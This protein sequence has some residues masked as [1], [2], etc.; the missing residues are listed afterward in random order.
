MLSL[1]TDHLE[2]LLSHFRMSFAEAEVPD[3]PHDSVYSSN[4]PYSGSMDRAQQAV[5][6]GMTDRGTLHQESFQQGSS[7]A[8]N[9]GSSASAMGQALPGGGL[10]ALKLVLNRPNQ[11]AGL[12]Q[13]SSMLNADSKNVQLCMSPM[14]E[15][16]TP[17]S[18]GFDRSLSA[19]ATPAQANA[20]VPTQSAERSSVYSCGGSASVN[21]DS[22]AATATSA[23][24]ANDC[25][26]TSG[27]GEDKPLG[28]T[29]ADDHEDDLSVSELP[30]LPDVPVV[31]GG[32]S[33]A[34]ARAGV[35]TSKYV[36]IGCAIACLCVFALWAKDASAVSLTSRMFPT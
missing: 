6:Q 12:C 32:E 28:S 18:T 19:P 13:L 33:G 3:T 17:G 36:H 10:T 14:S 9:P 25:E 16:M 23:H 35:G 4:A 29:L 22:S 27:T 2:A 8:Y 26:S 11:S 30:P 7:Q 34:K 20:A 1:P 21:N 5:A 15:P 24:E 31:G